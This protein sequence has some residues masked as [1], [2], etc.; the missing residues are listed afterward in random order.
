MF[1]HWAWQGAQPESQLL[2]ISTWHCTEAREACRH[3]P[4]HG[5][6]G[7]QEAAFL[8]HHSPQGPLPNST[9]LLPGLSLQKPFL[10][11][12]KNVGVR[13]GNR[14]GGMEGGGAA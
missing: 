9:F 6:P 2:R 12:H 10:C 11:C 8:T 4:G 5:G 13:S 3:G 7:R 1:R 14:Q